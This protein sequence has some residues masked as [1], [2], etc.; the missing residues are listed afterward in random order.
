ME[1]LKVLTTGEAAKYCGV[2]FRTIIRWIEKGRLKA[3]KLPGR[4]DHRIQITDFVDFLISN[5]MPVPG[6]LAAD[7]PTPS[8]LVVEDQLEMASAIRRVLRRAGF[9]VDIASD[10][11]VAGH[12][13]ATN[14]PSLITLDLKMPG[15]D[16]YEVLKFMREQPE[17]SSVKVLVVSAETESGLS[18]AL[19]Y[20]A[21][22]VLPKPFDNDQLLK[23]I[24]QL[25]GHIPKA[26]ATA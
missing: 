26:L 21:D 3:Y 6:E 2:N 11:F 20:G 19:E 25:I 18:K 9:D 14:K 15:M 16:G 23:K 24:E 5:N 17:Y 10:G 13:L 1:Q 8:I 12:M 4:G 22:E 7:A